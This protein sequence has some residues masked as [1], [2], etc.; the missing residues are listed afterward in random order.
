MEQSGNQVIN[1]NAGNKYKEWIGSDGNKYKEW[2]KS[3]GNKY[4]EWIGSDGNLNCEEILPNNRV[5]HSVLEKNGMWTSHI[6]YEP[7]LPSLNSL[8]SFSSPHTLP[9]CSGPAQPTL[10][11]HSGRKRPTPPPRSK[12]F[13]RPLL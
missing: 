6:H 3:D 2:I 4:K 5:I 1:N 7:T 13:H 8:P 12:L 10:P 11:P 9:S